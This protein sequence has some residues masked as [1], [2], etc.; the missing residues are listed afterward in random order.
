MLHSVGKRERERESNNKDKNKNTSNWEQQLTEKNIK[1]V[2]KKRGKWLI[3]L[4]IKSLKKKL[5]ENK[6]GSI[7]N[8]GF[9]EDFL[10]TTPKV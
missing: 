7:H 8:I 6:R 9:S 3:S 4:S 5:E 2:D 10:N 1:I